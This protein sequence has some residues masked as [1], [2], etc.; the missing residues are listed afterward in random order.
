MTSLTVHNHKLERPTQGRLV[1]LDD[2][3]GQ[4]ILSCQLQKAVVW[5]IQKFELV[6]KM[7]SVSVVG[8]SSLVQAIQEPSVQ[9]LYLDTAL[10]EQAL[11]SLADVGKQ[12]NKPVFLSLPL[13]CA[14]PSQ[15]KP[16]KWTIKRLLD[17]FAA[18]LILLV[19]SPVLCGIALLVILLSPGPIFFKQWRVGE[20]GKLFQIYK[21]RTMIVDAEKLHSQVMGDQAGLHKLENDPRVTSLGRWMRKYSLDELPQLLNVLRGEMSLVGPRPWA[22]Y[23]AVRIKPGG[24]HRLNALPGVTGAWQV[25]ARSTLLELDAVNACDLEYLSNWS[26][27][28]DFRLLFLTLPRVLRGFGAC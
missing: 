8:A 7:A 10:P 28:Q 11:R 25:Q 18:L 2:H 5:S 9:Q 15:R 21:F 14:L 1:E 27:V 12:L 23:D 3:K 20:Q 24:Q 16:L 17:W 4:Y 19:L 22:L 13:E 6:S 26:L